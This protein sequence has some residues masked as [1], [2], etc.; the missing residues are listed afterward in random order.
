MIDFGAD[1]LTRGRAHPLM[2]PAL[3]LQRLAA[4]AADPAC[5]VILLDVVLGH[6]TEPDPAALLAPAIEEAL[7]A[8][9]GD[10]SVVVSLCGTG[11]DP[12]GRDRQATTLHGAGA[13]VFASNAAAARHAVSLIE[14]P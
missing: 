9:P 13:S 5:G 1:E 14:E 4:E 12:Q 2:D 10:L 8:R 7:T 6:G 11:S 3:R